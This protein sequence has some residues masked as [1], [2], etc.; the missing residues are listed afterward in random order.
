M[1]TIDTHTNE[2]WLIDSSELISKG[3]L[4]CLT[5]N[6]YLTNDNNP[7][8]W[9]GTNL[10]Q[11]LNRKKNTEICPLYGK[12]IK[13][14]D[15]FCYQLCRSIPWG[16]EM[17]RNIHAIY[18]VILNFETKP[19]NRYF[20]W[21]DSQ[22][23]LKHDKSLFEAIFESFVVAGYLNTIGKATWDYQVNQRNIFLFEDTKPDDVFFLLDKDYY[24]P[25]ID[26]DSDDIESNNMKHDFVTLLIK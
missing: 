12:M 13:T 26:N 17:G 8:Q 7:L 9:F 14:I 2:N 22:I 1:K 24:T 19:I 21:Y 16:F 23:L 18:D 5:K 15:D 11:Y 20:I 6:E 3:S 10:I 25:R 4:I